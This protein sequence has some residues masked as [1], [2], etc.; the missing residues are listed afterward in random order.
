MLRRGRS[1]NYVA[2]WQN[3]LHLQ[4]HIVYFAVLRGYHAY[5]AVR[6]KT[7]H[8]R[9]RQRRRIMHRGVSALVCRPLE[10]LVYSARSAL[11]IHSLLVDFVNFVHALGVQKDS[12]AHGYRAALRSASA[13]P[14]RHGNFIIVCNFHHFGR[15]VRVFGRNYKIRL[16]HAS[17]SVRPHA[18]QPEIIDA[19][20][21]F[22]DCSYRTV[23][24]P[25]GV[26]QLGHY[27]SEQKFVHNLPHEKNF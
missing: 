1:V 18:R 25:D 16:G 4:Y 15:F 17:P 12:S 7:A 23:F 14:R 3:H 26:F 5:A 22:V 9:T 27:L 20:S 10:M 8:R 24:P 21:Q 6:Q 19:V 13:A 11:D 2:A